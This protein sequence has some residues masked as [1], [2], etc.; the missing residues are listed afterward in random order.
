MTAQP[1]PPP[2]DT[3]QPVSLG[4]D[5]PQPGPVL[6]FA[7]L[8]TLWL[9]ITGTI[10]NIACR[11]CFITCGPKNDSHPMMDE[12]HVLETLR[13]AYDR[14]VREYYFTGGEPFM[15]PKI[16]P[17]IEATLAQGP[18]TILTNGIL[19]TDTLAARLAE[20]AQASE[21]SLDVRVSI[22]GTTPE[23]NDPI[24]GKNTFHRI[25][26]GAQA[27]HRGGINPVFTVTTVHAR[28]AESEG[29]AEFLALL[30]ELGFTRPRLKMIPPF[31]LGREVRRGGGYD[32]AEYLVEGDLMDGEEHVLQCGSCRMVTAKGVYPCPILIEEEGARMGD[33]LADALKP[34]RLDQRACYTCHVEGFTCST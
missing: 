10:C 20:I 24:R 2:D 30:R 3:D 1:L 12:E 11:H 34:I 25:L 6:P 31:K 27:L 29:R 16:L 9:Q 14:G 22:D 15:H 32:A 13:E 7:A 19:I 5:T 26:A 23:E 33:T 28:L 4:G 21:Y 18:L 17:I 8:D